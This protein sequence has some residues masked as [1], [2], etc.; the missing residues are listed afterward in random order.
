MDVAAALDPPLELEE[1]LVWWM[2]EDLLI[3]LA[4]KPLSLLLKILF[5]IPAKFLSFSLLLKKG[6]F[7]SNLSQDLNIRLFVP[8]P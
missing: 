3:V 6:P 5:C 1:L 7:E 2:I 4:A 8:V